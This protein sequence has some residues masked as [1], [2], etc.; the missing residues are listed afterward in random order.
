MAYNLDFSGWKD[1]REA[2]YKSIINQADI[3]ANLIANKYD[4]IAKTLSGVAK[5]ALWSYGKADERA[6]ENAIGQAME[7]RAAAE[8]QGLTGLAVDPMQALSASGGLTNDATKNYKRAQLV[9]GLL[10]Y[11]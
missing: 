3:R 8:A 9:N 7:N 2:M 4:T 11:V 1:A 5:N 10:R 6:A